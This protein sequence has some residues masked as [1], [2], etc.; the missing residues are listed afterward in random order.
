MLVEALFSLLAIIVGITTAMILWNVIAS[1]KKTL[2]SK[3]LGGLAIAPVVAITVILTQ[4]VRSIAKVPYLGAVVRTID[5]I[6]LRFV[7]YIGFM[8]WPLIVW[9]IFP[10]LVAGIY[11]LIKGL[12]VY[13]QKKRSYTA[14]VLEER[15]ASNKGGDKMAVAKGGFLKRAWN[16]I[17]PFGKNSDSPKKKGKAKEQ[18]QDDAVEAS[19]VEPDSVHFMP[20][21]TLT[22]IRY[23]NIL[24][25]QKAYEQSKKFNK[26]ILDQTDNGY[27]GVYATGSGFNETRALLTKHH[28]SN[29]EIQ[30]LEGRPTF[31][32]ITPD[33][34]EAMPVRERMD[35]LRR[36]N[37]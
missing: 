10:V 4:L 18:V 32:F 23:G 31:V 11:L 22:R 16:L 29:D 34:I 14:S 27:V 30:K 25:V 9:F 33:S 5:N 35:T 6:W 21:V 15:G 36:E 8:K 20:D 26:L 19:G 17:W 2:L 12:L 28:Y 1:G 13:Q 3:L 7:G 24:G 37:G